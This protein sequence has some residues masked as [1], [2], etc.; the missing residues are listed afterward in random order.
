MLL[1]LYPTKIEFQQV[2]LELHQ[3]AAVRRAWAPLPLEL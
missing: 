2:N 3:E 1:S